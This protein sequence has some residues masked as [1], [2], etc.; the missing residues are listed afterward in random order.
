MRLGKTF[1]HRKK[2]AGT[3]PEGEGPGVNGW[4]QNSEEEFIQENFSVDSRALC[5]IA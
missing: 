4:A 3:V 2:E 5:I 1:A